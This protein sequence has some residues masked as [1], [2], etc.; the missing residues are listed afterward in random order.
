MNNW[1]FQWVNYLILCSKK[2]DPITVIP[3]N[4]NITEGTSPNIKKL[5]AIPNMGNKEYEGKICPTV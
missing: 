5:K 1:I 2:T 3:P 4:M